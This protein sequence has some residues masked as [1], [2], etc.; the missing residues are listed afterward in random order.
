MGELTPDTLLALVRE[1]TA[2]RRNIV[3]LRNDE[4]GELGDVVVRDVESIH[5]E[6]MDTGAWWLGVYL[7][8]KRDRVVIWIAADRP[9]RTKV[10][11]TATEVP[12]GA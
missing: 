4:A 6:R 3:D 1:C 7:R 9:G 2:R 8:G 10:R 12:R 5:L 11:A